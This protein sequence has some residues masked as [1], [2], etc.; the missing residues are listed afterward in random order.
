MKPM[1][2]KKKVSVLL[3]S[4]MVFSLFA[5]VDLAY[6]DVVPTATATP[7]AAT[8]AAAA[9][10]VTTPAGTAPAETPSTKPA[11]PQMD[12]QAK[13]NV[14]K[15][16]GILEGTDD[17]G[18]AGLDKEVTRAQLAKTI[19]LLNGLKEDKPSSE[20][21]KDLDNAAWAAGFIGAA[22]KAGYMEGVAKDQFAPNGIVTLEQA[23]SVL[24]RVFK[25]QAEEA[26]TS[27]LTGTVSEWA[28]GQ[29]AAAIKAGLMTSAADYTKSAKREQLV[30]YAY[31]AYLLVQAGGPAV[32][33]VSVADFKVTGAK[34]LVLK[35]NGVIADTTKL[36]VTVLR[37]SITGSAVTSTAKWNANKNEATITLDTKM[38]EGIYTLKLEAVKDGGLTIDKGTAEVSVS[39]E[40][41]TQ[42]DFTTA[43]ETV[44]QGKIKLTFKATNQYKEV[45]D[46]SAA[47]FGLY[48]SPELDAIPAGDSQSLTI[49]VTN[50]VY[51]NK[52]RRD[53]KFEV[54][55]IAPDYTVQANKTFTVGD[56]QTVS[57]IELG[58]IAYVNGKTKFEAGDVVTVPYKAFDQYGFQVTDLDVLTK[59]A[60][61]YSTAAGVIDTAATYPPHGFGFIAD[62]TGD[63]IPELKV[64][65]AANFSQFSVEDVTL[66][67]AGF[68]SGQA[69]TKV[70]KVAASKAPYDISVGNFPNTVA[71]GD[72]DFYLP[73]VVK[74]QGGNI[75]STDDVIENADKITVYGF[76]NGSA[77]IGAKDASGKLIGGIEKSGA[78][79]GTIRV[80]D[81]R[82]L[83][84]QNK[85]QLTVKASVNTSGK[86][87]SNT[88]N[89]VA[90]RFPKTVYLSV[91]PKAKMLPSI[92]MVNGRTENAFRLKFK[93]QYNED[94]DRDYRGYSMKLSFAKTS[95]TV[96]DAVYVVRGAN[97][98]DTVN[99]S[100]IVKGVDGTADGYDSGKAPA[101]FGYFRD[102]DFFFIAKT[103][104]N[105]EGTYQVV[106]QLFKGDQAA[107]AA[108]TASLISTAVSSTQLIKGKEA[109]NLVYTLTPFANGI[110]AV[111]KIK[112]TL[113]GAE[114]N[115]ISNVSSTVVSNVYSTEAYSL[116]NM[117]SGKVVL[118]AK[119][120]SG[121]VVQLP[122]NT[123]QALNSITTSNTRA[124]SVVIK[125]KADGQTGNLSDGYGI[126]GK[127]VGTTSISV[128]FKP[129]NYVG[130]KVAFLDSIAI[131][132]DALTVSTLTATYNGKAKN[133]WLSALKN[134][135]DGIN[136]WAGNDSGKLN[137]KQ[138]FSNITLMDQ[139]GNNG[140][141]NSSV[142]R[143]APIFGIQ[144]FVSNVK[145]ANEAIVPNSGYIAVEYNSSGVNSLNGKSNAVEALPA[146]VDPTD[147]VFSTVP[148][149]DPNKN[150]VVRLNRGDAKYVYKPAKSAIDGSV[151]EVTSFTVT[152][153]TASGKTITVDV[154]PDPTK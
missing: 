117:F 149:A 65:A 64:R 59:N 27:K 129:S 38:T 30:N 23:A 18:S 62:E 83:T 145:W 17:T 60:N 16:K 98:L 11:A 10:T 57:K 9:P 150:P 26:D 108:G 76:A 120:A 107:V 94:F 130:S 51:A 143:V 147:W 24:A 135:T 43:A 33:K 116:E 146:G 106:A 37:G 151:V 80:S 5:S 123:I 140:F 14:L 141:K 2:M 134:T 41:I 103:D 142:F 54:R 139:Y 34:T 69:A 104:N 93:D 47:I 137:Q 29:V 132:D 122:N 85:G 19:V 15:E 84:D 113:K 42:I 63:G 102:R 112:D 89:I 31:A 66:S 36:T 110:Y 127:D 118:T 125:P 82:T 56:P 70:L 133:I 105:N 71:V 28:K 81:L 48:T 73:I 153:I 53:S 78:N 58:E 90:K 111:D 79:R 39:N 61:A 97:T 50:A 99:S 13:F 87:A 77:T 67:V 12:T 101:D 21:Y 55:I 126:R 86:T 88:T 25:L 52:L 74:D 32:T 115:V 20:T 3:A 136:V 75:L 96:T 138:T 45:S 46:I 152:M 35:L 95:G 8:P 148:N 4:A 6:A 91:V 119:D 22:T 131:K 44:A 154:Y 121:N 92:E 109:N 128:V 114:N 124:S 68:G 100:F 1:V 72:D 40:K 7:A 144:F 49:D